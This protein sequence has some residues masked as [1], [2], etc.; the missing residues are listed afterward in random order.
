MFSVWLQILSRDQKKTAVLKLD[1]CQFS[2]DSNET[3]QSEI[4]I[5][6]E[7]ENTNW[8]NVT[9][10]YYFLSTSSANHARMIWSSE[11][12]NGY[13]HLYYVEKRKGQKES[14]VRQLTEGEWCCVDRP[15]FVDESRSLVYFSAKLHTPLETHFYVLNY[16]TRQTPKL[17]TR[18]GFSHTVTMNSPDYFIDCFS[19]LH[20][21]Q[22]T[23]VQRLNHS[24]G[25]AD[26]F[27]LL[28]PVALK[29]QVETPPSPP[30]INSILNHAP[31]NHYSQT[32]PTKYQDSIE[33]NGE[34]FSFN[35][36]DGNDNSIM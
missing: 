5:L 34:T 23:M 3:K 32:P 20:D 13:R 4:E 16:S 36:S 11:K 24:I 33:P 7:E 30:F 17:L 2:K 26:R 27:G 15:L 14:S 1:V 10:V 6:W 29:R 35:T 12:G 22:V 21:P 18:L 8:I 25:R 19:T 9:D 28:M 31:F